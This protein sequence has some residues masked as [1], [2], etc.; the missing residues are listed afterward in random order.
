MKT[1]KFNGV[2]IAQITWNDKDV[3]LAIQIAA[4]L[5]YANGSAASL[6]K[7]ILGD[8]KREFFEGK[9]YVWADGADAKDGWYD[10][11]R[12]QVPDP[13]HYLDLYELPPVPENLG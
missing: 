9:H 4:A 5:G 10:D 7:S 13:S 8:W 1:S 3:W 6:Q 12:R 2:D 11:E